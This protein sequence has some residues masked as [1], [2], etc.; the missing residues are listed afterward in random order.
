[1]TKMEI[2]ALSKKYTD[3]TAEEMGAL[4]GAPCEVKSIVDNPDGTHTV[5]LEWEDK[6]GNRHQDAFIVSDGEQGPQGVKG[7][8]GATGYSPEITV[9]EDTETTYRLKVTNEEGDFITP[10]LKGSGGVGIN[11]R[12]SEDSLIFYNI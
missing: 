11:V 3:D 8:T 6:S 4:K 10:N 7:D 2:Y 1:M 9:Y 12:V 5:T